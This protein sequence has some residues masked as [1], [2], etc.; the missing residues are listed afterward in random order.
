MKLNFML[1]LLSSL[2][3]FSCKKDAVSTAEIMSCKIDGT[4]WISAESFA[5]IALSTSITGTDSKNQKSFD[6]I[7][8]DIAIGDYPISDYTKVR[9]RDNVSLYEA[10]TGTGK[11]SI[12]D[13][14]DKTVSG[15]F[16]FTV[17]ESGIANSEKVIT[18]GVFKNIIIEQ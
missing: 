13:I 8:E 7:V 18:N 10:V 9:F 11:I 12:T 15:T 5:E 3:I 1:F 17:F 16:N 4:D 14:T 6:L 2:L